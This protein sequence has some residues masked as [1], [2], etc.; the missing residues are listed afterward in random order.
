MIIRSC[1]DDNDDVWLLLVGLV[2]VVLE[3]E[4]E[5]FPLL[6]IAKTVSSNVEMDPLMLIHTLL[7]YERT[8][9]FSAQQSKQS[10]VTS[11][12]A[13]F[14]LIYIANTIITTCNYILTTI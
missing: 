4:D 7:Q 1:P 10:N 5:S 3:V 2:Q 6:F 11:V 13:L 8:A 9:A 12:I 14:I